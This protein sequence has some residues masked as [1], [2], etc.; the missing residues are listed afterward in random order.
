MIQFQLFFNNR[1]YR[2][3]KGHNPPLE[4]VDEIREKIISEAKKYIK[5]HKKIESIDKPRNSVNDLYIGRDRRKSG[6]WFNI[7]DLLY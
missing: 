5:K 6:D 3:I 4:L 7:D 1:K 2:T